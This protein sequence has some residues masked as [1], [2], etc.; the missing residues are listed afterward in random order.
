MCVIT[1]CY[2]IHYLY[3]IVGVCLFVCLPGACE[4]YY[5]KN[6]QAI[7]STR[8]YKTSRIYRN[9]ASINTNVNTP[10]NIS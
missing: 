8:Y 2:Y 3:V 9:T 4:Q 7:F 10:S 1:R 6:S 5:A